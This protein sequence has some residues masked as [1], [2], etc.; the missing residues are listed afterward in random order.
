MRLEVG[1]VLKTSYG[2]GPYK[3]KSITRGCTCPSY[4][5]ELDHG[6]E[7]EARPPHIYLVLTPVD[8]HVEFYLNHYDEQTLRSVI[9]SD[10]LILCSTPEPIQTTLI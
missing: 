9:N 1:M 8:G 5:D 7:A 4:L 6:D 2:T 3:L 10:H